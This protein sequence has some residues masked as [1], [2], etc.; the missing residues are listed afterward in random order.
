MQR[1]S[2]AY[3]HL[4]IA[5]L[6]TAPCSAMQ[7]ATAHIKTQL[8]SGG[9]V[10]QA[11]RLKAN[12]TTDALAASAA[13]AAG[14]ISNVSKRVRLKSNTT[15]DAAA[16]TAAVARG[17]GSKVTRTVRPKATA[18]TDVPAVP[19]MAA[20][21]NQSAPQRTQSPTVGHSAA[22]NQSRAVNNSLGNLS[23]L[24]RTVGASTAAA[25]SGEAAAS[26]T[27]NSRYAAESYTEAAAGR[28]KMQDRSGLRHAITGGAHDPKLLQ[29]GGS[30]TRTGNPQLLAGAVFVVLL[31]VTL[32]SLIV[33]ASLLCISHADEKS[34]GLKAGAASSCSSWVPRQ[35]HRP[36]HALARSPYRLDSIGAESLKPLPQFGGAATVSDMSLST[37]QVPMSLH[38][39][40]HVQHYPV[41]QTN[42][43]FVY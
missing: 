18:M 26:N 41:L 16:V 2:F 14:H 23:L 6:L 25:A 9:N 27:S 3:Y 22:T 7:D 10:T 38:S 35:Q 39:A 15:R 1:R 5:V 42:E 19:D 17:N 12:T 43:R 40:A 4:A 28:V 24:S 8:F 31:S 13:A 20:G 11:V 29:V 30:S 37:H 36:A 34:A 33:V 32:L 21:R